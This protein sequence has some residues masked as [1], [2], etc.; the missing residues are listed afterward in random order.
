MVFPLFSYVSSL[1]FD[2]SFIASSL[3]YDNQVVVSLLVVAAF[4]SG[5]AFV[6]STANA[7]R[8]LL[9]APSGDMAWAP[10]DSKETQVVHG[11]NLLT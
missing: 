7:K 5:V 9:K 4:M 10:W 1:K 3:R 8:R 11:E 2:D 6:V